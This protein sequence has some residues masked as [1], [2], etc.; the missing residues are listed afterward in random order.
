MPTR[1][2]NN[3]YPVCYLITSGSYRVAV[4]NQFTAKIIYQL[5]CQLA[6]Q[7]QSS[8]T[9]TVTA[10]MSPSSLGTWGRK[11]IIQLMN[12]VWKQR[13]VAKSIIKQGI[14]HEQTANAQFKL[15]GDEYEWSAKKMYQTLQPHVAA[16][17][18]NALMYPQIL[19]I[20]LR[21]PTALAADVA[22]KVEGLTHYDDDTKITNIKEI[23][24]FLH[25]AVTRL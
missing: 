19:Q 2:R 17:L 15:Y 4:S 18:T 9:V 21:A 11:Y 24:N 3:H 22:M 14:Q 1:T 8:T 16:S 12:G 6:I 23:W 25:H 10:L 7:Q 5:W 20:I 13:L